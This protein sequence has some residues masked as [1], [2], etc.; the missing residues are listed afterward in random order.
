MGSLP[1]LF[2]LNYVMKT[3]EIINNNNY[4][5]KIKIK[6]IHKNINPNINIIIDPL[7]SLKKFQFFFNK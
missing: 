1:K 5:F 2:F 3:I 7:T 4:D 6:A